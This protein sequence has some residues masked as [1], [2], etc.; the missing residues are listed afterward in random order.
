MKFQASCVLFCLCLIASLVEQGKTA[1]TPTSVIGTS[2]GGSSGS[3]TST[4][5]GSGTGGG[6]GGSSAVRVSGVM[7]ALAGVLAFI[8]NTKAS[9]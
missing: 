2:P 5:S 6:G 8:Y 1:S 3:G 7:V 4:G 9:F